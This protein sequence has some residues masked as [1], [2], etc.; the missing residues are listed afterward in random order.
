M[1]KSIPKS[2]SKQST[3]PRSNL[4]LVKKTKPT[5]KSK[6]PE[7]KELNEI[8]AVFENIDKICQSLITDS[9]NS[10]SMQAKDNYTSLTNI[11]NKINITISFNKFINNI[12]SFNS[13]DEKLQDKNEV[14]F[15]KNIVLAIPY[16]FGKHPFL[17]KDI[18]IIDKKIDNIYINLNKFI[19]LCCEYKNKNVSDESK[20]KLH[21]LPLQELNNYISKTNLLYKV[22]VP[23]ILKNTKVSKKKTTE[24]YLKESIKI[25]HTAVNVLDHNNINNNNN[26]KKSDSIDNELNKNSE[27]E[28]VDSIHNSQKTRD[29][30]DSDSDASM[31]DKKERV[32][33]MSSGDS[34]NE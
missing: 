4:E 17:I 9:I 5:S 18:E 12:F 31:S 33:I 6:L 32:I 34:D 19:K 3:K 20:Q 28:S 29:I 21:K 8:L 15:D 16:K 25:K 10:D 13:C 30:A 22:E 7:D 26:I 27:S 14:A 24:N 23:Y 1:S 2:T 11:F